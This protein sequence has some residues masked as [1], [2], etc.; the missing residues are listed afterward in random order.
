[1]ARWP[2]TTPSARKRRRTRWNQ[3][4]FPFLFV[5]LAGFMKPNPEPVEDIVAELREAQTAA[6]SLPNTAMATAVDIG[7]PANIHPRNKQ[8]VGRRLALAAL[9]MTY[10]EEVT[11]WGPMYERM[12][13]EGAAICLHFTNVDRGLAATDKK[14]LAGF[15]IAGEDRHFVWAQA[16][17][18][19]SCVVVSSPE[20][21]YPVAVRYSWASLPAGNLANSAGLP[22]PPFRTDRWVSPKQ[23][24]K[25]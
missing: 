3:G 6:L 24:P 25:K 20:V 8:E 13:M 9:R 14:P 5:Q 1:M 17:I 7:D 22:A 16:L 18:E 23:D 19:G 2:S 4:A 12:S 15:A 10:R 21:P 11:G